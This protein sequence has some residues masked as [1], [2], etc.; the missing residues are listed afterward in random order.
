VARGGAGG[1]RGVREWLFGARVG[2]VEA[3]EVSAGAA[4]DVV[5]LWAGSGSLRWALRA[6]LVV[7]RVD[8]GVRRAR[9]VLGRV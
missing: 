2:A 6:V 4:A 7:V 1:V 3:V 5:A 8:R 9:G